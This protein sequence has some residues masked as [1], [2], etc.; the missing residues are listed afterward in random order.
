[1]ISSEQIYFDGYLPTAKRPVRISRLEGYLKQTKVFHANH[2]DL[3]RSLH[4]DYSSA[5][6]LTEVFDLSRPVPPKFRGLPAAPFLVPAVLDS[7]IDSKYAAITQ[8]V[9]GEADSF[10]A[11]AARASGGIVLTSDSDLLIHN[12]GPAGA[13]VFFDNLKLLQYGEKHYEIS[14]RIA[15]SSK[16]AQ[17]LDLNDLCRFAFELKEDSSL[18]L[19]EVRRRA[20]LNMQIDRIRDYKDFGKEYEELSIDDAPTLSSPAELLDPRISEMILQCREGLQGSLH[21]YMPFLI[22]DPSRSSAW[23][24][25][26]GLRTLAYSVMAHHGGF[27]RQKQQSILEHSR[28]DTRI[29]PVEIQLTDSVSSLRNAELLNTQLEV[30]WKRYSSFPPAIIWK[31]FGMIEIFSWYLKSER[32]LPLHNTAVKAVWGNKGTFISWQDIQ[33]SAQLQ[34]ALYSVRILKQVL[35]YVSNYCELG[36]DTFLPLLQRL[37]NFPLLRDLFP[38]DDSTTVAVSDTEIRSIFDFIRNSTREQENLELDD[39]SASVS[40]LPNERVQNASVDETTVSVKIISKHKKLKRQSKNSIANGPTSK[41]PAKQTNN[42]YGLLSD[43]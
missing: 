2:K 5:A 32:S 27:P 3:R 37:K 29:V 4:K 36:T 31:I 17:N 24:I 38:G 34:A 8:V 40:I 15:H 42:I 1:M 39:G 18:T 12:L 41:G 28:R 21:V 20:K 6:T 7:L 10:C 13:V 43:I 30:L 25:S 11:A 33:L 9:P 35:T 26:I 22:E 14:A 16:I 23:N 19:Q